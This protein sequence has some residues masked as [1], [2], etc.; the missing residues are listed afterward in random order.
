MRMEFVTSRSSPLSI[1]LISSY[2]LLT[3]SAFPYK[4]IGLTVLRLPPSSLLTPQ[5]EGRDRYAMLCYAMPFPVSR[6]VDRCLAVCL[7]EQVIYPHS[8]TSI[9]PSILQA[10]SQPDTYQFV[11]QKPTLFLNSRPSLS[12][13]PS[14]LISYGLGRPSIYLYIC[15]MS[16][17]IYLFIYTSHSKASL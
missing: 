14:M 9:H 4:V 17:L 10:G 3:W 12:F 7:S 8:L 1:S 11:T 13:S 6:L 2:T 16:L 15:Q 5:K